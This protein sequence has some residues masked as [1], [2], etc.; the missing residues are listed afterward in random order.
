M[1]ERRRSLEGWTESGANARSALH[2]SEWNSLMQMHNTHARNLLQDGFY[3]YAMKLGLGDLPIIKVGH[4]KNPKTRL[5]SIL[6]SSAF[7][8]TLQY[9]SMAF[10]TRDTAL[11][12][13]RDFHR[14][15]DQYRMN[16]E[17]FS[18]LD[19]SGVDSLEYAL[20]FLRSNNGETK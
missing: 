3:V 2:T 19:G 16:G 12:A 1:E 17:W 10:D 11:M 6:T 14:Q 8:V 9:V 5:Q 4:S 20:D 15:F 18:L 7:P 13:E